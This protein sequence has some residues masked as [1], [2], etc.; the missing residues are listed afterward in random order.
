VVGDLAVGL[1]AGGVAADR[2]GPELFIGIVSALGLS[3]REVMAALARAL[4]TVD[5]S[6]EEISA[7]DLVYALRKERPPAGPRHERYHARMTAGN[8]FR[9]QLGANDA[10]ARAAIVDIKDRR[11]QR[12]G[13]A[14]KA[15][16]RCAYVIRSLK[17]PEEVATLRR[18]YG[19]SF[20]LLA[21]YMSRSN[22]VDALTKL[23]AEDLKEHADGGMAAAREA[24]G[25]VARDERERA[26]AHGQ[27]L[28]ATFHLADVF[29]EAGDAELMQGQIERF[30][31][32]LFGHPFETPTR[33][34]L[35][36]F[37]AFG[38]ALR[39]AS[40]GRQVGAAIASDDGEVMALGTNEVARAFGGQYW[41]GDDA[42]RRDHTLP[43]DIGAE[44]ISELLRDLLARQQKKGW[45]TKSSHT[46]LDDLEALAKTELFPP[47][48][49][50]PADP[51]SL[52]E[53]A[54]FLGLIEFM[55]AVHAE[56]A[57]ITAAARMGVSI[58]DCT[59][60]STTFPCH[61][62]ARHIVSAGLRRV[63]FIEPYPKSR[64]IEM[65]SDSIAVDGQDE[66]RIPCVP[67]VGVAPRMYIQLFTMPPRRRPDGRLV[68]WEDV[69]RTQ[70]PRIVTADLG[71][72]EAEAENMAGFVG[73]L[74]TQLSIG[75][76]GS[77]EANA[78]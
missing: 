78:G 64:V 4:E 23:L 17:T 73:L 32:L 75:G 47:C 7:I 76:A 28:A 58:Q 36:M 52:R 66:D 8:E 14:E 54:A 72:L 53:R 63:V 22:R 65:F 71:Y 61:E 51:L 77:G 24:E 46:S 18:I 6:V 16:P 43:S 30:I 59:I 31:R 44:L 68:E 60:Y 10:I 38:A 74:K 39:S 57:A 3:N 20:I 37:L 11:R 29:I 70:V 67:Y 42:D 34:E 41:A 69:R 49:D 13:D 56:M 9:R 45:L 21:A 2:R 12:M 19:S 35:A 62:C 26:D 48:A 33:D 55:R 40:P 27:N 5:Y 50:S 25:L 1:E 15:F